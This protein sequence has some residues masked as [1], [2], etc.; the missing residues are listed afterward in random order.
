MYFRRI[1]SLKEHY[2]THSGEKPYVCR[3]MGCLKK[4]SK[5]N[6]MNIHFKTHF[7]K[8]YIHV[9]SFSEEYI[10]S[11]IFNMKPKIGDVMI[12]NENDGEIQEIDNLSRADLIEYARDCNKHSNQA[13]TFLFHA[14]KMS[15]KETYI[16]SEEKICPD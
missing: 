5:K 14:K 16:V 12:E 1:N 13:E 11:S 6:N 10:N 4:F 7:K 2:K 15:E 8:N 9:S 3:F